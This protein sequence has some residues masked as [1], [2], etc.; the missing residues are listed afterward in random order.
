MARDR[1]KEPAHEVLRGRDGFRLEDVDPTRT[2]GWKGGAKAAA[3]HMVKQGV[4]L[5]DLQE[6]LFAD[7]RSGG[8]RSVLLVLQGMDSAGKGGIVRHVIG[9]VDPQGVQ[10]HA[11]RVP[12]PQ[13]RAHNYLWRIRRALPTPGYLGVFDRSHY[14]DVL[15]VRVN[16]LADVD[17]DK[18]FD[19]INRFEKQVVDGGT[20]IVKVALM[21]SREEQGL[22]LME[23]LDRPDKNW[24]F[25]PG[26]VDTRSKWDDYQ[27]AYQ[28]MLVNTST[29]YAP[30]HVIPADNKWYARLAVT[31]LLAQALASL[32]LTWP[33]VPWQV[34]DQKRRLAATMDPATLVKAAESAATEAKEVHEETAAHAD[35]VR[36]V[37]ELAAVDANGG[38]SPEVAWGDD[39]AQED[40]VAATAEGDQPA[41]GGQPAP[42]AEAQSGGK[43]KKKDRKKG[44]SGKK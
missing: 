30:W 9:L 27:A 15:V 4:A 34:E 44:K 11:F 41:S 43:G 19:E 5:A 12:T 31:E 25:N 14:E 23:R 8:T 29:H 7:G 40:T 1:W 16:H 37:N 35:D 3:K 21:V 20:V 17:W 39:V 42:A 13:E 36:E 10:H 38:A 28:V 22:R 2:P 33:T 26:D 6:R 32:E 24:K 18:R